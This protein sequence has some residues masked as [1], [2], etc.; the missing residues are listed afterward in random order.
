MTKKQLKDKLDMFIKAHKP[1]EF[2]SPR[3]AISSFWDI[4]NPIDITNPLKLEIVNKQT[5]SIFNSKV[6]QWWWSDKSPLSES[7]ILSTMDTKYVTGE[8]ITIHACR[9]ECSKEDWWTNCFC[10]SNVIDGLFDLSFKYNIVGVAQGPGDLRVWIKES[11]DHQTN[12]SG[13][14]VEKIAKCLEF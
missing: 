9:Y 11:E 8:Y 14:V 12:I 13:E 6:D 10:K 1:D 4:A 2:K 7:D 3:L 5:H